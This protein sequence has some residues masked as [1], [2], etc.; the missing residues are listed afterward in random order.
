MYDQEKAKYSYY[1][2]ALRGDIAQNGIRSLVRGLVL[3]RVFIGI[4]KVFCPI[5]DCRCCCST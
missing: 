4:N 5:Q 1:C 3:F 2:G